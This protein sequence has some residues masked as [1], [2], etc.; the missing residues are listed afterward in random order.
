MTE[1]GVGNR[2]TLVQNVESLAQ[3]ALIARYGAAWYRQVGRGPTRGTALITIGGPVRR[4]GVV[5]IKEA[6]TPVAEVVDRAAGGLYQ[7]PR[8][9]LLGG[10]FGA[11][12]RIDEAWDLPL[13]PA[14]LRHFGLAFG[15]GLIGLLGERDCAVARVAGIATFLADGSAGQCGPCRFGLPA[16]A[17]ATRRLAACRPRSELENVAEWTGLVRGRGACRHPDGAVQQLASALHVFA[18]EF[19]KPPGRPALSGRTIG[20]R[21]VSMSDKPQV[22]ESLDRL[23]GL[24][25]LRARGA[26]I[27]S[28]STRGAIPSSMPRIRFHTSCSVRRV[29]P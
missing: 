11:W 22:C 17:T 24:R 19:R 7:P 8:A 18:D 29:V 4:P 15:C 3:A 5:E 28:S 9:V 10:Y 20:P 2:P 16:I 6:G 12:A 26:E 25:R 21:F 14:M 13:D 27:S 1:R 23:Q